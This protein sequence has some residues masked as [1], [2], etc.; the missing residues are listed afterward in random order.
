MTLARADEVMS[1]EV[2][3]TV[4]PAVAEADWP[5]LLLSVTV[6]VKLVVPLTCAVPESIP[7]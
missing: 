4:I 5:G 2:G 3:A 1:R 6:A 7:D